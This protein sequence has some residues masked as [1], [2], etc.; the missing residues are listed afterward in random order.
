MEMRYC[1]RCNATKSIECFNDKNKYCLRCLEKNREKYYKNRDKK[2]ARAKI[3]R[4]EHKEETYARMK[5]YNKT[6]TQ[7]EVRCTICDCN[8]KKCRWSKHCQTMKHKQKEEETNKVNAM[9]EEER[10]EYFKIKQLKSIWNKV[11]L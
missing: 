11:R 1:N 5:E 4:S 9:S 7:I 8:V 6:Y 3:Y 10:D 2:N